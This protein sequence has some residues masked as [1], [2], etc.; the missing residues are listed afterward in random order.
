[1]IF[2]LFQREP[3]LDDTTRDWIHEVFAWALR[4][5]G[6]EVFYGDT[7]LVLPTPEHFPGR[8]DSAHAMAQLVFESVRGHAGLGQWPCRLLEP[9]ALAP[10]THPYPAV[11]APVRGARAGAGVPVPMTGPALFTYPRGL[12]GNPETLIAYFAQEFGHHL[13]AAA[14]EPPPAGEENQGHVAELLGV[15]MGFG[16]MFANTAFTVRVNSCGACQGPA[17]ERPGYLSRADLSYAL[18]LFCRLK[19]IPP[20]RV[21]PHLKSGLRPFFRRA[22]A[23]I[24]HS[25]ADLE[26]LRGAASEPARAALSGGISKPF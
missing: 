22:L 20:S 6:S 23:D 16:I 3:L 21:R 12:V 13:T 17:A 5:Q 11:A 15:F 19:E 1:M 9:G 7:V 18:A 10:Q 24:D 2:G 26:R 8:A 14:P 25:P 4:Y